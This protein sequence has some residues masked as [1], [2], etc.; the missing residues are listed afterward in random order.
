MLY[1]LFDQQSEKIDLLGNFVTINIRWFQYLWLDL[2]EQVLYAHHFRTQISPPF[3]GYIIRQSMCACF[4]PNSSPVCSSRGC[5]LRYVRRPWMPGLHSVISAGYSTKATRLWSLTWPC[6][7][8]I[9]WFNYFLGH[10]KHQWIH[11]TSVT[12]QR[13]FSLPLR[14]STPPPTNHPYVITC[15]TGSQVIQLASQQREH[16]LNYLV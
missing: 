11:K 13:V 9:Y 7:D 1:Q 4:V 5:F 15:G 10:F 12:T 6:S 3:Y 14:G 2:Q 16:Q 8:I